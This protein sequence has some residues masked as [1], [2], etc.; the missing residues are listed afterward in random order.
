[1][2]AT[3]WPSLTEYVKYLGRESICHVKENDKGALMIAWKDTS[4][5]AVRR[6]EAVKAADMLESR[7]EAGEDKMLERMA[8]RAKQE[9]EAK[10]KIAEA[11]AAESPAAEEVKPPTP[12]SSDDNSVGVEAAKTE[13][14]RADAVP[15]KFGFGLKAK[16]LSGKP[17]EAPVKKKSIFKRMRDDGGD[18]QSAKKM[19]V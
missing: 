13:E 9:A 5:E 12:P 11:K 14:S 17:A 4:P 18:G 10:A 15:V 3:K 7:N 8:A 2:N 19:K 6:R 1:M 16:P